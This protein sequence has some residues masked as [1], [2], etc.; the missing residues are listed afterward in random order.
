MRHGAAA[1]SW[2]ASGWLASNTSRVRACT[3]APT[4]GS[5]RSRALLRWVS[6]WCPRSPPRQSL[7]AAHTDLKAVGE[8]LLPLEMLPRVR[9]PPD[10]PEVREPRNLQKAVRLRR[11]RQRSRRHTKVSGTCEKNSPGPIQ[12]LESCKS[13]RRSE[14]NAI[15]R[16]QSERRDTDG[17]D[18]TPINPTVGP[19]PFLNILVF[20]C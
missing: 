15:E 12:Q 17:I 18:V 19:T 20:I 13:A 7:A 11:R 9:E 16:G 2:G 5:L 10:Q 4:S 14:G 1:S 6:R 3:D 8:E